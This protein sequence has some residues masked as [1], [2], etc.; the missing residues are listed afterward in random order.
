MPSSRRF[1]S[2]ENHTGRWIAPANRCFSPHC[3]HWWDRSWRPGIRR[4]WRPCPVPDYRRR[5]WWSWTGPSCSLRRTGWP[6]SGR[7]PGC[8]GP[9]SARWRSCRI[10]R[11]AGRGRDRFAARRSVVTERRRGRLA[12]R[13]GRNPAAFPDNN[14]RNRSSAGSGNGRDYAWSLHRRPPGWP[15][16]S[17]ISVPGIGCA[18]RWDWGQWPSVRIETW[19]G[20]PCWDRSSSPRGTGAGSCRT[21]ADAGRA[22]GHRLPPVTGSGPCGPRNSI[23]WWWV[24]RNHWCRRGISW[25]DP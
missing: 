21:D 23:V 25:W 19:S 11:S 24:N 7:P 16:R 13:L 3:R 8:D 5:P 2:P 9:S 17:P 12:N 20:P 14:R 6:D 1:R 15:R 10:R 4:W 18:R 22:V